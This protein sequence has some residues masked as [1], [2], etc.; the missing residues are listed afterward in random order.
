MLPQRN[1]V[2]LTLRDACASIGLTW[3]PPYEMEQFTVDGLLTMVNSASPTTWNASVEMFAGLVQLRFLR[4][5][6]YIR[7]FS[8]DWLQKNKK[9][10]FYEFS[11]FLTNN[12]VDLS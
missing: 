9:K 3:P 11:V 2:W 6:C 1:T 8:E 4:N 7:N 12:A 10:D 5:Q